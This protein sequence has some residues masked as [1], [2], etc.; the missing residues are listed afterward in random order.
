MCLAD[1]AGTPVAGAETAR[2]GACRGWI[3][4][5]GIHGERVFVLIYCIPTTHADKTKR[6]STSPSHHGGIHC[7]HIPH[8]RVKKDILR[9]WLL[10]H[11]PQSTQHSC[12]QA[13]A[14]HLP[15]KA[16]YSSA[17]FAKMISIKG[18]VVLAMAG[19]V[20][21]QSSSLFFTFSPAD[22]HPGQVVS[23]TYKAPDLQM[24]QSF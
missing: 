11:H 7:K 10:R 18:L 20:Y 5:H 6:R 3:G 1:S 9:P 14:L 24:V 12:V 17:V 2:V 13:K 16:R 15:V 4:P 22:I 23:I 8:G 19:M 21:G